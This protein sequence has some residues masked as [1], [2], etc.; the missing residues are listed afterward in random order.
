MEKPSTATPTAQPSSVPRCIRQA[1]PAGLSSRG[2]PLAGPR[3]GAISPAPRSRRSARAYASATPA[4]SSAT[5][6]AST[7]QRS[8]S[9]ARTWLPQPSGEIHDGQ[10]LLHPGAV[11]ALLA[12][13]VAGGA[14]HEGEPDG[15]GGERVGAP[16][17]DGELGGDGGDRGEGDP[18]AADRG[19]CGD[20]AGERQAGADEGEREQRGGQHVRGDDDEQRGGQQRV[21]ADH[22]GAEQLRPAGLLV[23]AGVP[24]HREGAQQRDDQ[25]QRHVRLGDHHRAE[26]RCRRWGR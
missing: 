12:E 13:H 24:D 18:D 2:A 9:K 20:G 19:G 23:L 22:G 10:A 14:Q 6:R 15:G 16:G 17:G 3:R 4:S 5:G 21:P 7:H 26:A 11:G 1:S 8:P 25:G